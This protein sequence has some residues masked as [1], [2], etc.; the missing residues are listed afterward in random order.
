LQTSTP[1]AQF[2]RLIAGIERQMCRAIARIVDDP[3]DAEDALQNALTTIWRKRTMVQMHPN[4]DA[5]VLR[6]CIDAAYDLLR[7]GRR[8]Q[9]GTQSVCE[10]LADPRP[11]PLE[12]LFEKEVRA[13]LLAAVRDLPRNQSLAVHMRFVEELSYSEIA[14]GIGCADSTA[15][16]H[17]ERGVR[18]LRQRLDLAALKM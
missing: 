18:R 7:R 5:I 2:D 8:R 3:H 11:E 10:E 14:A 6:V 13:A 15:R 4:R 16:K 1:G 9:F 17:V 12:E